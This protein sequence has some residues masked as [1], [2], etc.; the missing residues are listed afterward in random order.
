MKMNIF[1]NPFVDVQVKMLMDSYDDG[2]RKQTE[3]Y[4]RNKIANEIVAYGNTLDSVIPVS[5]NSQSHGEHFL[6]YWSQYVVDN[7]EQIARG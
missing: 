7:C 6:R 5:E 3:S 1:R 4:W 2:L